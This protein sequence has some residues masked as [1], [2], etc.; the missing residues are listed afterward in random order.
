MIIKNL[1]IDIHKMHEI[2]IWNHLLLHDRTELMNQIEYTVEINFQHYQY[3]IGISHK[4][5]D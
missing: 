1:K 2:Y 3:Q 4:K 5:A